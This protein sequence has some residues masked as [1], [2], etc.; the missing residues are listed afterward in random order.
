MM[1]KNATISLVIIAYNEEKKIARCIESAKKIAD[2]IIVVDSFSTDQ[3]VLIAETLGAIV[4]QHKFEGH[5]EQKNYAAEK[6][7]CDYVL[8]LDADEALDEVL[9]NELLKVKERPT[10]DAYKMNRVTNFC[11]KWIW[12]GGWYP[13]TKLR[14]WKNK[15]GAW[16]GNNPHDKFLLF[17]KNATVKKLN[18]NILHYSFDTIED[19]K[20]QTNS[21]VKISANELFKNNKKN[22]WTGMYLNSVWK[23][24]RFYF[25]KMGFLDGQAGWYIATST[26]AA[27]Y[28]KYFLLKKLIQQ[29]NENSI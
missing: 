1:N 6:A 11:G 15:K 23:F 10:F 27:T 17:D 26:A 22:Y 28:Q 7:Q 25:L 5:I 20:R 18:G 21:F 4:I 9:Q 24:I 14:L 12:H 19:Y 2:E 8:S 16:T 3:T 29:K 13:D